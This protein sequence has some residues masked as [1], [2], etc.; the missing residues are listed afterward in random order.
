[1]VLPMLRQ[2]MVKY[3]DCYQYEGAGTCAQQPVGVGGSWM[4][5]GQ[6][7]AGLGIVQVSLLT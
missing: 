5:E 3:K 1:M 6:F 7:Y 4:T 2:D